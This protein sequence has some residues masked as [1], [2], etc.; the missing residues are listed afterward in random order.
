MSFE[1]PKGVALAHPLGNQFFRRLA[2]GLRDAGLLQATFTCVDWSVSRRWRRVLPKRLS[3]E[4]DRR[5]VSQNLGVPV[6]SHPWREIGRVAA[7]PLG[8]QRLVRHE[9]GLLSVDAVFR[10]FDRW[11]A[12]RLAR[13]P[14]AAMAYA[15]EDAAEST[16]IEASRL[17]WLRAYDLP[18]AYWETSRRLLDEEAKLRPEWEPTLGGTRDSSNKQE[19]KTN[20]LRLA[21]LVICPSRF[22]ADSLPTWAR[23]TR[24]VVI[25]PF[26][27]PVPSAARQSRMAASGSRKLRVLFAGAMSQRKG[28]ADLF[29]AVRSL[30]R[31]DIE[32]VV[33]GSPVAPMG[34]YR[35]Q[36]RDFTHEPPRPHSSVLELMRTCDVFCLPSIV[37]GRALVIQE[38]MSQGLP[39]IVTPNTGVDDA[40]QDGVNG[41]VVP[42]RS[43]EKIAEKLFWCA[44]HKELLP[45]L[46][47]AAMSVSTQFSWARYSNAII[48]ALLP[49]CAAARE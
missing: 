35:S 31:P 32:L 4:L 29:N 18:I 9:V 36:L 41:F 10:D 24:Q 11:V 17:G 20:E 42:I 43:P 48:S 44:D 3:A 15:Y 34:F 12:G 46:G 26:G 40:V 47:H 2:G 27:S 6:A 45:E 30:K 33:M 22:V 1:V 37:E 21:N 49:A 5:S 14:G 8:F 23:D 13:T 39:V 16:F 38:A 7:G 19:R 28:L 25:A